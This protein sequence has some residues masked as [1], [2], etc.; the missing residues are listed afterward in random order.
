MTDVNTSENPERE[1]GRDLAGLR[2]EAEIEKLRLEAEELRERIPIRF[3]PE[4]STLI[5]IEYV[6]SASDRSF[7]L[8]KNK[9]TGLRNFDSS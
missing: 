4:T 3:I 1:S 6:V 9:N 8:H 7:F 2:A 5:C